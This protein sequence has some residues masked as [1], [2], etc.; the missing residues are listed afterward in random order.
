MQKIIFLG[1]KLELRVYVL[2]ALR[3]YPAPL[4]S[5]DFNISSICLAAKLVLKLIL[6]SPMLTTRSRSVVGDYAAND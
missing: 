6:L 4:S 2:Y 3:S 1:W 5:V